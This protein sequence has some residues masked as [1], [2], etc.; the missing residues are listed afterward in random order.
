MVTGNTPDLLEAFSSDPS[1][2]NRATGHGSAVKSCEKN[3]TDRRRT[4]RTPAADLSLYKMG[5]KGRRARARTSTSSKVSSPTVRPWGLAA[6]RVFVERGVS[7]SR[8]LGD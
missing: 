4:L 2:K 7:G 5:A 1:M 8:P 6:D 3:E